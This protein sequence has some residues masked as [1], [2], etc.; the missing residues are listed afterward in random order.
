MIGATRKASQQRVEK[1]PPTV[2]CRLESEP[3]RYIIGTNAPG[4]T[5]RKGHDEVR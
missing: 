1:K 4:S 5:L 3:P 2:S